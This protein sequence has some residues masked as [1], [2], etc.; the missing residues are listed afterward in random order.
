MLRK[1]FHL[2]QVRNAVAITQE[3]GIEVSA[4]FMIG[5]PEETR[6][7]VLATLKLAL[8]LDLDYV[9]F[10][11]TTPLPE[12]PLYEW[13]MSTG[14]FPDV[15]REFAA[16]P[17]AG[18]EYPLWED[19]MSRE[20]LVDLLRWCYQS[21]YFRPNYIFKRIRRIRTGLELA[22]K[23]KVGMNLLGEFL[24]TRWKRSFRLLL[25]PVR[26]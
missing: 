5:S 6:E 24:R 10:S 23:V 16:Q 13:G 4:G 20:E 3:A 17:H 18:A 8:E 22:L 11:I 12:T 25:P 26:S 14:K 1:G 15:W 2:A 7:D 19:R 21:F 9:Q